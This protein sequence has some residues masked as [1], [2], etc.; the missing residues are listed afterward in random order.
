MNPKPLRI[1]FSL[2]LLRPMREL[3]HLANNLKAS[4]NLARKKEGVDNI[5]RDMSGSGIVISLLH[6]RHEGRREGPHPDHSGAN[7]EMRARE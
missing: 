2:M 5:Q 3:E 1:L 4:G 7:E 6:L